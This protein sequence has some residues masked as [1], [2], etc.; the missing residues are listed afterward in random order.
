MHQHATPPIPPDISKSRF[1]GS[2]LSPNLVK[3]S[4][5]YSYIANYA[6]YPNI[7][8]YCV[9]CIALNIYEN[10]SYLAILIKQSIGF[11]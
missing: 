5:V 8:R 10:P 2:D 6:P 11:L 3:R 1:V 4:F 7:S 9:V